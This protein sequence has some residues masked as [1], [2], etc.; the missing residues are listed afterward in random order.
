MSTT[1]SPKRHKSS[2]SSKPKCKT[3]ASARKERDDS[4]D[5]DGTDPTTITTPA[6]YKLVGPSVEGEISLFEKSIP[7]L[8]CVG[9]DDGVY[10]YNDN[11]DMWIKI[12]TTGTSSAISAGDGEFEKKSDGTISSMVRVP[13]GQTVCLH[14]GFFA[15]PP[16]RKVSSR[17]TKPEEQAAAQERLQQLNAELEQKKQVEEAATAAALLDAKSAAKL[18]NEISEKRKKKKRSSI[19]TAE[20]PRVGDAT[21]AKDAAEAEGSDEDE[22]QEEGEEE[23]L[24]KRCLQEKVPFVDLTF[25]PTVAS[26]GEEIVRSNPKIEWRRPTAILGPESKITVFNETIE[27]NDACQGRLGD[28]YL[29]SSMACLAEFPEKIKDMFRH[30]SRK[31]GDIRTLAERAA[32]AYRVTLCHEGWWHMVLIDDHLLYL[33]DRGIAM[34]RNRR[35]QEEIWPCL[36]EKAFAKLHGSY[37]EIK[38]GLAF[39]AMRELT[40]YPGFKMNFFGDKESLFARLLEA[41]QQDYLININTPSNGNSR[42]YKDRGEAYSREAHK[43]KSL[44]PGHAYSCIQVKE[45]PQTRGGPIRLVQIRNPHGN[46]KEWEGN[47]NRRNDPLWDQHPEIKAV[48]EPENARDCKWW[49]EWTDVWQWFSS[50]TIC[51]MKTEWFDYRIRFALQTDNVP[52]LALELSVTGTEPVSFIFTLSNPEKKG[53]YS[54]LLSVAHIH[55]ESKSG[56]TF[57]TI[58]HSDGDSD[59]VPATDDASYARCSETACEVELPSSDKPYLILPRVRGKTGLN[60]KPLRLGVISSTEAKKGGWSANFVKPALDCSV[61][62]SS[63]SERFKWVGAA[64]CRKEFQYNPEVGC[65]VLREDSQLY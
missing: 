62:Q 36:I 65:H 42:Y 17:A 48:C 55:P 38:G 51:C 44:P 30:P 20:K 46:D 50:A 34:A 37:Y 43:A 28:C 10:A 14:K 22:T 19:G 16:R 41:D 6:S 35:H 2:R 32:H 33:P 56:T 59:L 49:M 57:K 54:V 40:G 24:L 47:W 39:E 13:P 3:N 61:Y 11:I 52:D 15:T 26:I 64:A 60:R 4:D 21:A 27:P 31:H 7:T 53:G 1:A 45:F 25:P 63:S 29:I 12:H 58:Y 18:A 23:L 9:G 5:D 8:Y